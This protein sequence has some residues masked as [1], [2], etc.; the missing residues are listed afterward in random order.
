LLEFANCGQLKCF[1]ANGHEW[2]PTLEEQKQAS[3]NLLR[4][5]HL[6]G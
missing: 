1:C 6:F 5:L 4:V 3:A 2:T